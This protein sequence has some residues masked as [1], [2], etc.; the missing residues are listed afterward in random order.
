MYAENCKCKEKLEYQCFWYKDPNDFQRS[1]KL[2]QRTIITP[3]KGLHCPCDEIIN[4]FKKEIIVY[5]SSDYNFLE[6]FKTI[7]IC[8]GSSQDVMVDYFK[9]VGTFLCMFELCT[10]G[11]TNT[12]THTHNIDR[13]KYYFLKHIDLLQI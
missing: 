11:N 12:H 6:N 2:D 4:A 7:W 10:C 3:L 5:I 1:L 8:D 13:L 9:K